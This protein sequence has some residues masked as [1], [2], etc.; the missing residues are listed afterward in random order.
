MNRVAFLLLFALVSMNVFA[1]TPLCRSSSG[2]YCQY[3]G[4]VKQIYVNSNNLIILYFDSS[5]DENAWEVAGYDATVRNAAAI[6]IDDNP[7]F[8]KLFYSTALAAQSSKRSVSV[9]MRGAISG[10]MKIDR[11]WLPE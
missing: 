5:F 7:D 4:P 1:A 10:Y 9:Q 3:T 6:R 2:G 11:I 8:A